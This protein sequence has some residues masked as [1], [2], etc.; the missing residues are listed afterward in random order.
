MDVKKSQHHIAG[1]EFALQGSG[2][3]SY[4]VGVT[5]KSLIDDAVQTSPQAHSEFKNMRS[6]RERTLV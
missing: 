6:F 2:C 4:G 3:A 5:G 1:H